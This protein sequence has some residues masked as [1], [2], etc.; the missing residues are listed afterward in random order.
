LETILSKDDNAFC[1]RMKTHGNSDLPLLNLNV[2]ATKMKCLT[3]FFGVFTWNLTGH[4]TFEVVKS[5]G[6]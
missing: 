4:L 6:S 5:T 2:K 1:G 3:Q